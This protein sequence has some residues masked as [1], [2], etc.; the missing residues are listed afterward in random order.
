MSVD[1][2]LFLSSEC[3]RRIPT[4]FM[5]PSPKINTNKMLYKKQIKVISPWSVLPSIPTPPT[6]I[7]LV[8]KKAKFLTF[9][10]V[11]APN[12]KITI[13]MIKI[14]INALLKCWI[15]TQ[16]VKTIMARNLPILLILINV[17]PIV[18]SSMEIHVLNANY[19]DTLAMNLRLVKPVN[20]N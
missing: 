16:M 1:N 2:R 18:H 6:K 14:L 17:L 10:L 13:N 15:V 19:Q 20:L 11:S 9:P 12:A 8:V 5:V 4:L 7:A 3:L